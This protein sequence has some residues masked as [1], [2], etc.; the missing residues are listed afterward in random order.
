MWRLTT[1]I[2]GF[3]VGKVYNTFSENS[4]NVALKSDDGEILYV[5]K[6]HLDEV[7]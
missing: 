2:R 5:P 7:V 3:T 6:T 4:F 1:A